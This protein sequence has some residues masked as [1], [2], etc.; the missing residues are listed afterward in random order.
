MIEVFRRQVSKQAHKGRLSTEKCDGE[1]KQRTP[2]KSEGTQRD[3]RNMV[4]RM[5]SKTDLLGN[6]GCRLMAAYL[7]SNII[8]L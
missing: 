3:E 6:L 2:L 5:E 4:T 1:A 8:D 7:L